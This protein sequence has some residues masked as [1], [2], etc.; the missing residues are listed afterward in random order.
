VPTNLAKCL[1]AADTLAFPEQAG[2]RIGF[3][4]DFWRSSHKQDDVRLFPASLYPQ[5]KYKSSLR[6]SPAD[7]K[8]SYLLPFMQAEPEKRAAQL[9]QGGAILFLPFELFCTFI[10]YYE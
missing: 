6:D 1:I 9:D 2:Q 3:H 8:H 5:N 7:L 10:K 4:A